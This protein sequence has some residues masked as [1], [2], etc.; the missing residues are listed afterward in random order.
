MGGRAAVGR[1]LSVVVASMV[2]E[3]SH[4]S[5]AALCGPSTVRMRSRPLGHLQPLHP[6]LVLFI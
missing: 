4:A 3:V 2:G 5:V 1:V 6:D